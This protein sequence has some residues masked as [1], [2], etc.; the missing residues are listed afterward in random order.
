MWACVCKFC[1]GSVDGCR[2]T[3]IGAAGRVSGL[4]V[5]VCG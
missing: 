2:L 1:G 5:I 3:I 4:M